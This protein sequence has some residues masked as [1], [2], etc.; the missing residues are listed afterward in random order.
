M[1]KKITKL[2]IN[3]LMKGAKKKNPLGKGKAK[4]EVMH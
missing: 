4:I 1:W 2:S 3:I